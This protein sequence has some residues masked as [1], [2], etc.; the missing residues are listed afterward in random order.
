MNVLNE[1]KIDAMRQ[2]NE[3]MDKT[4]HY[5]V[6]F[7]NEYYEKERKD[8]PRRPHIK[9]INGKWYAYTEMIP[10]GCLPQ[11]SPNDFKVFAVINNINKG[12]VIRMDGFGDPLYEDLVEEA[13]K[14]S[15]EAPERMDLVTDLLRTFT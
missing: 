9:E 1:K 13:I 7:S 8:F 11:W 6:T 12:G 3:I 5:L 14:N 4:E 2:H 10:L 15:L